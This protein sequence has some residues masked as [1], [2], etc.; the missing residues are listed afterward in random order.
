[1]GPWDPIDDELV[2]LVINVANGRRSK[3]DVAVLLAARSCS[4]HGVEQRSRPLATV[5]RGA[6]FGDRNEH[7]FRLRAPAQ[8]QQAH[9]AIEARLGNEC[10]RSVRREVGVP[11][12]ERRGR[13][14]T[15]EVEPMSSLVRSEIRSQGVGSRRRGTSGCGRHF[16]CWQV[17]VGSVRRREDR[18]LDPWG[19]D[20]LLLRRSALGAPDTSRGP[21]R[22]GW[23]QRR[24]ARLGSEPFANLLPARKGPLTRGEGNGTT[25]RRCDWENEAQREESAALLELEATENAPSNRASIE[26][27]AG[28]FVA[29][30]ADERSE[31][32]TGHGMPSAL[33]SARSFW[34]A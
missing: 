27:R 24:R 7:L 10:S 12:D 6:A 33:S 2:E 34:R 9:G 30:R 29:I 18:R 3:A 16:V 31:R 14:A 28:I 17:R 20:L 11:R 1:L 4:F 19:L 15:V 25:E 8:T 32:I 21:R 5:N 26:R 13:L 23:L 22:F